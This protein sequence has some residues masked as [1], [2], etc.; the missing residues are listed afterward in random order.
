MSCSLFHYRPGEPPSI[1]QETLTESDG[2]SQSLLARSLNTISLEPLSV[3]MQLNPRK[4][5][6][7]ADSDSRVGEFVQQPVPKL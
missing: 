4:P 5:R 2:R 6:D 1:V 3:K 7:R